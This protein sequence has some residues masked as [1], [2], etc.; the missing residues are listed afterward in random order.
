MTHKAVLVPLNALE[1]T[2]TSAFKQ[3]GVQITASVDLRF[4]F[5]DRN[6]VGVGP[7]ILASTGELPTHSPAI[8][9]AGDRELAVGHLGCNVKV[10]RGPA[11]G[12][13]LIAEVTVE[14]LEPVGKLDGG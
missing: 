2:A 9:T 13:E 8:L 6:A 5:F 3:V 1:R 11:D 14:R 10:R 12:R 7:G 4:V